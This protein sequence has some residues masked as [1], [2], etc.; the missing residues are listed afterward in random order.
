MGKLESPRGY[1]NYG[2]STMPI[3]NIIGIENSNDRGDEINL[4]EL[5]K[6]IGG[7]GGAKKYWDPTYFSV[8][9]T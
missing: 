8:C 6:Y 1:N 4:D 7:A 5:N 3:T 2:A 9:W